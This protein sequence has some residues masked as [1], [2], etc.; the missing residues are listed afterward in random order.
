VSTE[1]NRL[2]AT[3][4]EA[5]LLY[6]EVRPGYPEEL[7]DDVVSL[8]GIPAG[9]R[10][11]EIGCGTGRATVPFARP[12]YRIVCLELGGNLDAVARR[13]L[14]AYP[15]AE[16]YIGPF[17]QWHL[18]DAAFDLA[19]SATAF[20]WLNPEVLT[21]R[22]RARSKVEDRSP[23]FGTC[24]ST[25]TRTEASSRGRRGSTSEKRPRSS[26]PTTTRVLPGPTRFPAGPRRSRSGLFEVST[27]RQY[28]WDETYDTAGYL[29]RA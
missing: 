26:V 6:E 27:T 12:G 13:N 5:A 9:G 14:E 3:F 28:G 4:D 15:Q 1:R 19:V 16:V 24:A 18:Q 29:A 23:C 20:H 17:E 10:I 2:R 25:R 22:T 21:R 7:F 11:L 8:R